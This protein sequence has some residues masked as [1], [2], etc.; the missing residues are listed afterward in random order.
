LQSKG[1]KGQG[2]KGQ[3]RKDRGKVETKQ[4]VSA[5]VMVEKVNREAMFYYMAMK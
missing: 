5:A 3:G 2:R 1:K 4:M